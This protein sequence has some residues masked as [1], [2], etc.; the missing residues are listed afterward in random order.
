MIDLRKI[1]PSNIL[2][3]IRTEWQLEDRLDIVI[4]HMNN[5]IHEANATI[6]K[7]HKKFIQYGELNFD[8]KTVQEAIDILMRLNGDEIIEVDEYI[9]EL[10]V[11]GYEDETDDEY[12]SRI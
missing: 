5:E 12:A 6:F 7:R 4:E 11:G 9:R 10:T 1:I 2:E 8:G 3:I